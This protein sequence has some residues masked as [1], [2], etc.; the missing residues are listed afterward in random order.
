MALRMSGLMSGMDTES[1]IQQLVEAKS[2]KVTTAKKAQTKLSWKQDAWKELNTKLKNLQ[3]KFLSNMRFSTSYSKRVTKVSNPNAVSVITGENAVNGVQELQVKQLAK[4]AYLTGGVVKTTAGDESA[5][6]LTKIS[7]L[8][9]FTGEGKINVTTGNTSVDINITNDTTISDVLTQ[10]KNAGLNASF[11]A[12]WQRFSISAKEPGAANDF[13]ITALDDNGEN[14][15]SAMQLK[16]DLKDDPAS[17]A[18]YQKYAGYYV[19]GDRVATL[20]NM[21]GMID[22][23]VASRTELYLSQYKSL[24]ASRDAAQKTIDEINKKY[25]DQGITLG[26][27][28]SYNTLIEAKNK[29]IAELNEKLNAADSPLTEADREAAEKRIADL[30]EEVK[31]LSE[32]KADAESLAANQESVTKLND[33][34]DEIAGANGYITVTMGTDADG[35][36][37]YT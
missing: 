23:D 4:T 15:L 35:E 37:T 24:T 2:V 12:K 13:S 1:I 31:D 30:Q 17:L 27:A 25:A 9:G 5:T 34:I 32:K 8:D 16:V 21:K 29:E 6:A 19:A 36:T 22:Q 28:E 7:D 20:A 3:S 11:D 10:L 14:A 33:Q 26:T 18:E